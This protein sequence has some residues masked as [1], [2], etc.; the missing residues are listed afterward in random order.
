MPWLNILS[1]LALV[2]LVVYAGRRRRQALRERLQGEAYEV[3]DAAIRRIE[4]TGS[5][6]TPEEEPLDLEEIEE[7]ERRFWEDEDWNP[8][9]RL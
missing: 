6:T 2:A 5:L 8:A 3:D 7:E 1:G 4:R 9:E